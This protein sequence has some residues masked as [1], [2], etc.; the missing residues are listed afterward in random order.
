MVTR[1]EE[2]STRGRARMLFEMLDGTARGGPIADGWRS[3]AVRDALDLC[4]ACKGCRKDCPVNVDM[5]TYKA[6]FLHQ[7]Y[8]HRLRPRSHYSMGWLPIAAAAASRMPR[9][10]N[11]AAHA[12]LLATLAKKVAG[13]DERRTLPLFAPATFQQWFRSHAPAGSGAR[14]D[15]LLWPDTFTNNFHPS[16]GRAAVEVLEDAGFRVRVPSE[17]VCCGLTW[18][19]TGQLEMA[20]R[21]LM[22]TVAICRD[23]IRA[24]GLVV[25]LEPSCTAV[26]R[27]DAVELFPHDDDVRRLQQQT[28]TFAELLG[29]CDDWQPPTIRRTARV[30]THCHHHAIMGFQ[31]DRALL[32]KM[33][34]DV[35]ILDSG[36]CGLAGNFG[37][38]QGHY[39]VSTACAERVLLPAVRSSA[40]DDVILADG[41]S[42]R[43]QIEQNKSRGRRAM[44]LAE[45]VRAALEGDDHMPYPER[46][47]APRP[48]L[49]FDKIDGETMTSIAHDT[50]EKAGEIATAAISNAAGAVADPKTAVQMAKQKS[51]SA[52]P[53]AALVG[54]AI[55]IL[56][57]R[58]RLVS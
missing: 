47:W 43:T 8:A 7:H 18:I 37:F 26:F 1:E 54:V 38:E 17:P 23:H 29:R 57:L 36:C 40:A 5:A 33:G 3:E 56:F 32:E 39:E 16:I 53:W 44:H 20:K 4:L 10:T 15:V 21:V 2:H 27:S 45:L 24:G 22:R 50:A 6:E 14:D 13:V 25:G 52:L 12:P 19:S 42:C 11:A 34:V 51:R 31:D 30:Q 58:R 41:F 9:V 55:A 46:R 35:D 49:G 48:K 28:V